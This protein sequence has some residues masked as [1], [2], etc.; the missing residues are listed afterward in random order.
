M[1]FGVNRLFMCRKDWGSA[2]NM[3]KFVLRTAVRKLSG[4]SIKDAEQSIPVRNA[5]SMGYWRAWKLRL[6]SHDGKVRILNFNSKCAFETHCT[7]D[8][9]T[10]IFWI[11]QYTH[12]R[13]KFGFWIPAGEECLGTLP[14][15]HAWSSHF[16]C[17]CTLCSARYI[18]GSG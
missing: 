3:H 7:H 4:L 18:G 13:P 5:K 1:L 15:K 17:F 11:T 2:W 12:E 16:L 14:I 8:R 9:S 10:C 6:F